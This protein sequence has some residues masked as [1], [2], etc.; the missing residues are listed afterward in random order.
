[1]FAKEWQVIRGC[2]RNNFQIT[3]KHI[4]LLLNW[5]LESGSPLEYGGVE[6][7][8]EIL[9]KSNIS[10]AWKN[11]MNLHFFQVGKTDMAIAWT[12]RL[13]RGWCNRVVKIVDLFSWYFSKKNATV[14]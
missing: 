12:D 10:G 4:T 6:A 8:S 1:M 2:L 11:N 14:L 13:G 7:L 9:L 3:T 5:F